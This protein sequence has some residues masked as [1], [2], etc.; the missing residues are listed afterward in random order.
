MASER[1]EAKAGDCKNK[2]E[3]AWVAAWETC[4][5]NLVGTNLFKNSLTQWTKES[6][7][8]VV[9]TNRSHVSASAKFNFTVE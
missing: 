1:A 6:F 9:K 7:S 8:L 3:Q 4:W 5:R 2:G